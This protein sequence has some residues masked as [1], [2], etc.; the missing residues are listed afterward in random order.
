[1]T[2]KLIMF[3]GLPA[4]GKTTYW[5]SHFR[6]EGPIR[7]SMDTFQK[8]VTGR[9]HSPAFMGIAKV[10]ID[11]THEYLLREGHTVLIDSVLLTKGVRAKL[12]RTAKACG[13]TVELYWFDVPFEVCLER[14]RYRERWV[15][16]AVMQRMNEQ[17]ELPDSAEE[18][19]D[20][21]WRVEADGKRYSVK[22]L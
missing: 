22:S 10:W 11:W 8:M 15:P 5:K 20:K 2:G 17:F 19:F 16:E 3:M 4:S 6:D 7:L 12:V 1:M 21:L 14:N 18:Q 9:D 13:A